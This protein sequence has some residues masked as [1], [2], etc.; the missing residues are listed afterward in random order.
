[1][2]QFKYDM[3]QKVAETT[4]CRVCESDGISVY[5]RFANTPGEGVTQNRQ[6]KVAEQA[7]KQEDRL[8]DF[9]LSREV[10]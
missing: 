4:V 2:R 7:K 5:R 6:P 1:M 9:H 3:A 8:G 10:D